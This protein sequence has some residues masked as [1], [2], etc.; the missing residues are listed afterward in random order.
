MKFNKISLSGKIV[1]LVMFVVIVVGGATFGSAYYF[2]SKAFDEQAERRVDL[3]AAGVQ[4]SVDDMKDKIRTHAVSFANLP[5]LVEAVHKKD[6]V[7]LQQI[8]N[9]L[10]ANYSLDVLTITDEHGNVL[11]RGHSDSKGDSVANQT[12]V[13]KALAGEVSV[14]FEEGT[15]AKFSLRAGGPIKIDGSII[16]T[17]AT[18][19]DVSASTSFVDNM[20]K[21]F[22]VECTVFQKDVRVST[23]LE[24]D[25]KRIIGTKMDNPKVIETVL[26]KGAKIP[27]F[28]YD[29]GQDLQ[30]CLL[31][32][33]RSGRQDCGNAFSWKRP[34]HH[35]TGMPEGNLDR[36]GIDSHR[37]SIDGC[38]RL[39]PLQVSCQ[40]DAQTHK[41]AQG[42][43]P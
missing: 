19:I 3:A 28:E 33:D 1:A 15:V 27:Q 32:H 34:E 10:L 39:P 37:R 2:F 8:A 18:G 14:G 20:K 11:A 12:N 5:D 13:R 29:H 40:T 36:S 30:H 21:R 35:R 23:T 38:G 24:R 22:N 31:A 7:H 42:E 9:G 6:T 25:G 43:R 16:G 26:E 17:I 41:S 4:G